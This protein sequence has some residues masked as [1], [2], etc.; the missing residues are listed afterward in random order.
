MKLASIYFVVFFLSIFNSSLQGQVS[1][2]ALKYFNKAKKEISKNR[3]DKA[4]HYL[5]ESLAI[6]PGYKEVNLQLYQIYMDKG[7]SQKAL[8]YLLTASKNAGNDKPNLLYNLSKLALAV[9]DYE[10][11][12]TAATEY[13]NLNTKDSSTRRQARHI[14]ESSDYSISHISNPVPYHP[15]LL[16]KN[17]NTEMPEYLPS[18]DATGNTLVF[19]R[20]INGNEDLFF[21]RK[22]NNE[23]SSAF[24]W[25]QNTIQN[26][27]AHTISA[28]GKTIV[29]TRCNMSDGYG[30]C[31]LYIS[32]LS[33]GKWSKPVN[34]GYIVNSKFWESQPCLSANGKAI[35]FAS[36]RPGGFGGYDIW[37]SSKQNQKWSHPVN[38]G[39]RINTEWDEL[40]PSYHPDGTHIY[41]RSNGKPGF[42]SFDLFVS[43][44]NEKGE[45]TEAEN[46]GF[47]INDYRDQGAMVVALDGSTAYLSDQKISF[48]NELL[49][50][51][52]STFD[53][54]EKGSSQ[55]CIFLKG[56]T[57]DRKTMEAIPHT[58]I[59]FSSSW[60]NSIAD[61]IR[62]DM[63]GEFLLVLPIGN[64]YKVY[65]SAANFEFFSDR[66]QTN[67]TTTSNIKYDI[68]LSKIS[69][70]EPY[71]SE[72]PIRLSNVIFETGSAI[73]QSESFSE[74]DRL[75]NF[76][77]EYPQL[78]IEINGHTD[79]IGSAESNLTLSIARAK[80]VYDYFVRHEI[81]MN[82]L[83]YNGY[84]DTQ[85]VAEN[86]TEQGRALNRRV[87]LILSGR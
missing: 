1:S 6:Q 48:K 55:P 52:I 40:S 23:W 2:K 74:L 87:E 14:L 63:D 84:G 36:D 30:S 27:G 66:I 54:P 80:A 15:T 76:L 13:I 31:D 59:L 83:Q 65:A 72:K 78:T 11:A 20:R 85:P 58:S 56:R 82:R 24:P 67:T 77:G 21:T 57:L 33:A 10:K 35:Y 43:S 60:S 17:I 39:Q 70:N 26:E 34:M 42:G 61:T 79:N 62:S 9:G 53:L 64:V 8:G 38:L 47:P 49:E 19:T 28:D 73:L 75:L 3:I 71:V 18:L 68:L 22:Q 46:L 81:D 45:W 50:S 86:T 4:V 37:R 51:N 44:M 7:D 5:E 32:E 12:K 25:S 29:F 69:P 16:S 41:F